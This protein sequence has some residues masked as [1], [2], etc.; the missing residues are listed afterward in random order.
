MIASISFR[1]SDFPSMSKVTS[2]VGEA[3]GECVDAGFQL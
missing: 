2:E 3:F 1:R